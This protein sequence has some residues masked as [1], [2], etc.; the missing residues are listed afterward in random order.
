MFVR[1]FQEDNPDKIRGLVSEFEGGIKTFRVLS[2]NPL[3][4]EMIN[5]SVETATRIVNS[6]DS[7]DSIEAVIARYKFEEPFQDRGKQVTK[8]DK[9]AREL[10]ENCL[11]SPEALMTN[12]MV[13]VIGDKYDIAVLKS[14]AVMKIK[15]CMEYHWE[16]SSFSSAVQYLY[17]NTIPSDR[18]LREMF[19]ATA[20]KKQESLT[21]NPEFLDIVTENGEI[22]ADLF[23]EKIKPI[24]FIPQNAM[25]VELRCK[26]WKVD[27]QYKI[28]Y[29]PHYCSS[30]FLDI[31]EE[32]DGRKMDLICNNMMC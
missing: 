27:G 21:S 30:S 17:E 26:N 14:L 28:I 9:A 32:D 25:T 7:Q 22:G 2:P 8:Y 20:Y 15:H 18:V 11:G 10:E 3:K 19:I 23:K 16:T 13:Y 5:C 24:R 31:D 6:L 4:I 1:S 29:C 12:T